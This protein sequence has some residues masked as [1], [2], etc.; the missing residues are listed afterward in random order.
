M[1]TRTLEGKRQEAGSWLV[2]FRF[3]CALT[4]VQHRHIGVAW[5]VAQ[6]PRTPPDSR[7]N[8]LD[9]A[10]AGTR[11]GPM[12]SAS[13]ETLLALALLAVGCVLILH[14]HGA[15]VEWGSAAGAAA[16]LLAL[17]F[18]VWAIAA[19]LVKTRNDPGVGYAPEL[20]TLV[21][22]PSSFK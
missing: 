10:P 1:P 5:P 8:H 17:I 9:R 12:R 14:E 16:L 18:V 7:V 3:D 20:S 15:W 11:L 13:F 22:P 19:R 2:E 4:A 21:F 6:Q